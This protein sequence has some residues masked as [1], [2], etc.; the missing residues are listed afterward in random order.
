M[1]SEQKKNRFQILAERA[2]EVMVA[3]GLY[4]QG[5][6]GIGFVPYELILESDLSYVTDRVVFRAVGARGCKE[7][8]TEI[9][10]QQTD[11]FFYDRWGLFM[12]D[13]KGASDIGFKQHTFPDVEYFPEA[14]ASEGE[15]FYKAELSMVVN[16]A[17]VLPGICTDVFRSSYQ[18]DIWSMGGASSMRD[19]DIM[20]ILEGTK[21]IAFHLDLPRKTNWIKSTTRLRLRL[22]GV[23]VR[24][25][26]LIS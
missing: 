24:N 6:V 18:A 11:C 7:F 17:V 1:Q 5:Q 16:N 4:Q 20:G 19:T 2:W 15:I 22:G 12:L 10:L 8:I 9:T 3:A 23:L 13:T 21:S 25:S 14:E 26:A